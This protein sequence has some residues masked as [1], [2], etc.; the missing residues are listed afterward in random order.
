MVR[1]QKACDIG[2]GGLLLSG[3]VSE[4]DRPSIS[5]GILFGLIMV[6]CFLGV[7]ML[8]DAFMSAIEAVT[9]QR[10]QVHRRD[11]SVR[12]VNVWN[13]TV[14]NLTLMALGS[15]APEIML[16]VIELFKNEMYAGD[17]GPSTIVGSAAFNLLVIIAACIV[18]IPSGEG[19]LLEALPA[20][21]ITAAFSLFAYV[22]LVVILTIITP[23]VVDIW[24]AAF[25]FCYLPVLVYVSYKVDVNGNFLARFFDRSQ[26]QSNDEAGGKLDGDGGGTKGGTEHHREARTSLVSGATAGSGKHDRESYRRPSVTSSRFDTVDHMHRASGTTETI[27]ASARHPQ[28]STIAMHHQKVM[29]YATCSRKLSRSMSFTPSIEGPVLGAKA[30]RG[31]QV[32]TAMIRSHVQFLVDRQSFSSM[33]ANKPVTIVRDGNVKDDI[34]VTYSIHTCKD[35]RPRGDPR[36]AFCYPDFPMSDVNI[37]AGVKPVHSDEALD[38]TNLPEVSR[39]QVTFATGDLSKDIL[40]A[41]PHSRAGK[42][43]NL[44]VCLREVLPLS[45]GR[46]N[47]QTE[48]RGLPQATQTTSVF[49]GPLSMTYVLLVENETE[50]IA[51]YK[52]SATIQASPHAVQSMEVLVMRKGGCVGAVNCFYH[53]E[54][55]TAVS[56]LDF[57]EAKGTIEFTEGVTE[58]SIHLKVNRKREGRVT[59]KFLLVLEDADENDIFDEKRDG[60]PSSAILTVVI[61][62]EPPTS[63]RGRCKAVLDRMLNLESCRLGLLDWRDQAMAAFFC[64]GS[65][66]AQR[67]ASYKDLA[68]HALAFP[69]KLMLITIPPTTFCNGW[70]CFYLSLLEIGVVTAF[71]ADLAELFGCV[72]GI[73]DAVTAVTFVALGTSVPDLFASLS[74][75]HEDPNADASIINVTGSN[76][77]NVF[78][79][80]GLPWTIATIY[81]AVTPRSLEWE[82]TYPEIAGQIMGRNA[83]VVESRNLG[84]CVLV[85]VVCCI[86]GIALLILRRQLLGFELGGPFIPKVTSFTAFVCLW[87]GYIVL[88]SWRFLRYGKATDLEQW[89][90]LSVVIACEAV[91][92]GISIAAMIVH[93]GAAP[94]E[95]EE[96][97]PAVREEAKETR[98]VSGEEPEV[99]EVVL[100]PRTS[101]PEPE[102]LDEDDIQT[103]RDISEEV[104]K[105]VTLALT[106]RAFTTVR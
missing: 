106:P 20:F 39:G 19:R 42:I 89:T 35:K 102:D 71:L 31:S 100:S 93:R 101:E 15:S 62:V 73:P 55:F 18:A 80:L 88:A 17:L 78:L 61:E 67:V 22:W 21:Y 40:V 23:N 98:Q 30:N 68:F 84:F 94:A 5:H 44:L 9:S 56:G 13:A 57:E 85:F 27:V 12:T 103:S 37:A 29:Q 77:V 24:E 91:I 11:G 87:I 47:S 81:W 105:V 72:L 59:D 32:E 74:A 63:C 8:A 65:L 14:A 83:F 36:V 79:G 45:S 52:E 97:A 82:I 10:K 25:T 64:D 26:W 46:P 54:T 58:Q 16:S 51:F 41:C 66:E 60:G 49:I 38:V 43:Q 7:S 96:A 53:T 76:S 75:A 4:E 6:Y 99:V 48:G 70:A 90:I 95:C 104:H 86:S 2:G 33:L 1:G 69:W 50:S 92:L 28:C 3:G 34:L